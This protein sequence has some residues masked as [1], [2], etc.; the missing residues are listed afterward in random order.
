VLGR[1]DLAVLVLNWNGRR[2]LDGCLTAV[3]GQVEPGDEVWLVD[4]GSSD[5]SLEHVRRAFPAVRVVA[6]GA[7]LGFGAA[8]NRAV[9]Q[10]DAGQLLLINNDLI[11]QP[12]W[13]AALRAAAGADRSLAAVGSK[14]L[15]LDRPAVV[16]HA[17]GTLT[18]LGSAFDVGL[19]APDGPAFERPGPCGCA[20]GAAVL[21]RRDAFLAVGGFDERYFAYF[22]DADLCWRLWL[23]GYGVRFEPSARALHAYGGSTGG[24]RAGRLRI[25]HCQANRLQNMVKNLETGRL[26]R[27]L[28]ASLAFDGWRMLEFARAGNAA[29]ARALLRGTSRFARLLPA[30]LAERR[31]V[32][33]ARRV[34]DADL[35]RLGA[36][37]DLRTAAA[38]WRRLAA[39]AP[40]A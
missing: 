17:G 27:A 37:V 18:V 31:R 33:S 35:L 36:L 13:L 34:A 9:R 26:L 38:E 5:G 28:P 14:L 30:V 2:W 29:S 25:E 22:E 11:V 21:V 10:V 40:A 15:F 4:N 6:H 32:Q 16:N 20:T 1:S 12:G 39:L 8:Y 24:G 3:L 23:R 7:N 19:G